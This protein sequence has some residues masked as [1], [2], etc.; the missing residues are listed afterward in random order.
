MTCNFCIGG[1]KWPALFP[2][3]RPKVATLNLCRFIPLARELFLNIGCISAS[4]NSL[5]TLLNRSNNK[6]HKS[7]RDGFTSNAVVLVVGGI[8]EQQDCTYPNRYR[9]VLKNRRGFVRIALQS[10]ASL[11]PSIS[12]GENDYYD[13]I[14]HKPYAWMQRIFKIQN[15]PMFFF[16]RGYLQYNFGL[17]PKRRPITTVIGAPIHLKKNLIPSQ[18]EINGVHELFCTRLVQL[19]EEHKAKYVKNFEHVHLEFV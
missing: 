2:G 6:N 11:V 8:R 1:S 10:G 3:I 17:I 4:A 18:D 13:M 16:G 7:N 19:F 14:E 5:T 12:F 15:W 9:F